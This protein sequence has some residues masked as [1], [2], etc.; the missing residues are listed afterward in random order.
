MELGRRSLMISETQR[1]LQG[2]GVASDTKGFY[3]LLANGFDL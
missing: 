2:S 1:V 3:L